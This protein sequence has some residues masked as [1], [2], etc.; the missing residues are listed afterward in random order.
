M[1]EAAVRQLLLEAGIE[2]TTQ[3]RSVIPPLELDIVVAKHNLAIEIN[4]CYWHH[5]GGSLRPLVE[6]TR[7]VRERGMTLLHFWDFEVRQRLPAVRNILLAKLGL[8]KKRGARTMDLRQLTS[9]E[10]AVFLNTHHLAGF[11]RAT[12]HLGLCLD[13]QIMAVASFNANRFKKDGSWELVRYAS[14]GVVVGGLSRLIANFHHRH[15]VP[16][17]AFAD[18]RIS[19]GSAYT[20][21]GFCY[22][23][24]TRPGYFYFKGDRRLH[25]QQAMKH[26]LP[27]ILDRF[28][29]V[30]SEYQNMLANGWLR[31]SDCG[32]YKFTLTPRQS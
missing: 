17:V 24:L 27:N 13:T 26:K 12:L 4:G 8:H 21:V 28:D 18:A 19:V 29:P 7:L 1:E 14:D 30:M 6:K 9:R 23:G 31:C 20:K 25:R 5:D 15:N 10:A 11:A 2:F 32:S 22:D 3:D 16:L